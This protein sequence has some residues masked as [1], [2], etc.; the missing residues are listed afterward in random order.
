VTV[1]GW[2]AFAF[3]AGGAIVFAFSVARRA[4]RR[5]RIEE[6]RRMRR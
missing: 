6:L 5:K 3:M 2:L 4:E 1:W